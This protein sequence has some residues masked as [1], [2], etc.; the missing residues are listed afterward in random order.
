MFAPFPSAVL[1]SRLRGAYALLARPAGLARG[2]EP[3]Y[4]NATRIAS[5]APNT[6]GWYCKTSPCNPF[7]SR[8]IAPMR[9]SG[10]YNDRGNLPAMAWGIKTAP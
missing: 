6:I 1:A 7:Q 8:P 4:S 2:S 9:P 5:L 10:C 3:R